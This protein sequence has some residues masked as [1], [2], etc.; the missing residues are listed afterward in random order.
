M[1]LHQ[2]GISPQV[3]TASQAVRMYDQQ[4]VRTPRISEFDDLSGFL[5]DDAVVGYQMTNSGVA[6]NSR[7]DIAYSAETH[8]PF[9]WIN[10]AY[11][12]RGTARAAQRPMRSL[13]DLC[14]RLVTELLRDR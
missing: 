4:R 3:P 9:C 2:S 5:A 12:K 13:D 8:R 10:F 11:G 1:A 7:A 6:Y 14:R